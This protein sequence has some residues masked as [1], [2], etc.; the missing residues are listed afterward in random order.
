MRTPQIGLAVDSNGGHENC[1]AALELRERLMKI[2]RLRFFQE[3][4]REDVTHNIIVR[5][6]EEARATGRDLSEV[7]D[8]TVAK[9]SEAERSAFR[10]KRKRD[11]RATSPPTPF[12]D[13]AAPDDTALDEIERYDS[14]E[15]I[16][17]RIKL[18][19]AEKEFFQLWFAEGIHHY[20]DLSSRMGKTPEVLQ[21]IRYRLVEKLKRIPPLVLEKLGY[22]H[23]NRDSTT[24]TNGNRGR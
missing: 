13:F 5:L 4:D 19:D 11:S 7:D 20:D 17:V 22:N 12:S 10:R 18:T 1:I 23:E 14:F 6:L 24:L 8:R 16:C 3:T 2:R 9:A 15:A 21:R